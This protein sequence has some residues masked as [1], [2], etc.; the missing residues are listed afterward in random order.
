MAKIYNIDLQNAN[1]SA[2]VSLLQNLSQE[3]IQMC[4][5]ISSFI[6]QSKQSLV[7]GGYDAVRTKLSLYIDAFKIQSQ[8]YNNLYS[9]IISSNNSMSNFMEG[10]TE[11]DDSK[12]D[13][14]KAN[15]IDAK[16]T[17]NYLTSYRITNRSEMEEDEN[18]SPIYQRNGSSELINFYSSTINELEKICEKLV[19][20][21]EKDNQYFSNIS[22]VND[23]IQSYSNSV[24]NI[25]TS[26]FDL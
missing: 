6:E 20:L 3:S 18:I 2:S 22:V 8:V 16:S 13:E 10:Y 15:L 21:Q 26:T 9:N 7:G 5:K 23:D 4:E 25:S 12:L 24:N 1:N 14:I 17:L 19:Q 11:L